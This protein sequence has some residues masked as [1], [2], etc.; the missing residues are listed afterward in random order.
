MEDTRRFV[1]V[2]QCCL[3]KHNTSSVSSLGMCK[4]VYWMHN[5]SHDCC[6]LRYADSQPTSIIVF[7]KKRQPFHTYKYALDHC[8][9]MICGQSSPVMYID[10][11][12]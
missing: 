5:Q 10:C 3:S 4:S 11:V 9:V 8:V 12:P 6:R 1:A 2:V 7:V